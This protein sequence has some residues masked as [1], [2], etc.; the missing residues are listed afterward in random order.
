[1]AKDGYE[2]HVANSGEEALEILHHHR[3]IALMIS[4]I[5]MPGM[6]GIELLV[7]AKKNYENL[8]VLMA[9]AVDDRK[10]AVR[11]LALGGYGYLI[12]PFDGNEILIN[13]SNALRFRQLEMENKRHLGQLEEIVALRTK[14]LQKTIH[15]LQITEAEL[16]LSR[17]ETI[18]RLSMAAEFRDTET[19][20]HTVR[21]S[22]YCEL[23][24]RK[25]MDNPSRCE[26]IRLASP[27]HD[28]GKIGIPDNV[29]LKPGK[30]TPEEFTIIKTHSQ[31][32][33]NLLTGSKSELLDLAAL[34]ALTHHEKYDGSGY[35]GNLAGEAIPIEGRIVAVCDVF[36]A[37]TSDRIYKAAFSVEKAIEIMNEGR[38]SHFD[39]ILLDHFLDSLA[40]FLAI[41]IQYTDGHS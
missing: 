33:F 31:I 9:S 23:L 29:L 39:P 28:V 16:H 19:Y 27:M 7:T 18:R 30:L 25:I 35:P 40:E 24:A 12:K 34:I 38:G 8:A 1:V 2:T 21:M 10:I 17:E 37:L 6:S 5:N 15:Q 32:G 4:D 41:K 13:V 3:D 36:D 14:E 26:S 22:Y 11:T 20:L